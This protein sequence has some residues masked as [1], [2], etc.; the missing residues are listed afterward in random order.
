MVGPPQRGVAAGRI[1]RHAVFGKAAPDIIGL[2]LEHRIDAPAQI[3][4]HR[5]AI[6]FER[7]DHFHLAGAAGEDARQVLHAAG[8]EGEAILGRGQ[9]GGIG[10]RRHFDPRF[11]AIEEAVEHLRVHA[12]DPRLLL[13]QPIMAPDRRRRAGVV[14]RQVFGALAGGDHGEALGAQR[15]DDLADQRRLV[16]I[17]HGIDH[18]RRLGARRQQRPG[19]HI[20][21]H[22]HH[23]DML[24]MADRRQRVADAGGRMAGAFDDHL[25]AGVGDQRC[26]IFGQERAAAGQRG[27]EAGRAIL[28]RWPADPRQPVPRPRQ[29]EVGDARHLQPGHAL[30]AGEEHGAEFAGANQADGD[31]AALGGAGAQ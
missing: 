8:R 21:L 15:V 30:G 20:G 9:A 7:G 23:D 14:F 6:A 17:G 16:A 29:G 3:A 28:R 22:I 25:D 4:D 18:A 11:R 24:A 26:R 10:D 1:G 13:A 5:P 27:I 12:A 31:G 19:Q 2:A